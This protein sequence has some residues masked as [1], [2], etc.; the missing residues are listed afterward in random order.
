VSDASAHAPPLPGLD[1]PIATDA[2]EPVP[3]HDRIEGSIATATWAA[4]Q[5][6]RMLRVHDVAATVHA[7]ELVGDHIAKAAA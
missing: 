1:R 7:V 4:L 2:A 6:A 3:T 5:G